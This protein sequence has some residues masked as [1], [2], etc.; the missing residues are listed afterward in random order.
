MSMFILLEQVKRLEND[1]REK[2]G[3]SQNSDG[4]RAHNL[5]AGEIV[6]TRGYR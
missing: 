6:E 2:G 1:F 5:L 4:A 3:G